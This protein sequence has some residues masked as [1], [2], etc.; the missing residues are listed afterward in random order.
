[1]RRA[2]WCDTA[3]QPY[4]ID[5][6]PRSP[7]GERPN[8]PIRRA[9][10]GY[11]NPRSPWGERLRGSEIITATCYFNPRSPWGERLSRCFNPPHSSTFQSTLSMRR[12]T[13]CRPDS[14][15]RR[16]FNPRSPWGERHIREAKK[17]AINLNFNPRSPWGERPVRFPRSFRFLS[18][19]IH[20]LHEESDTW[21][22]GFGTRFISF[23]STLSMRRATHGACQSAWHCGISIH[24]LHE[25]SDVTW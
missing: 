11:F 15:G 22:V 23:Q 4:P 19:S 13:S 20:A 25:E 6:N 3:R 9:R 16:N 1:M 18:I 14:S 17:A 5:F 24:A 21:Y 12:A 7:W 8:T 10:D 2:T